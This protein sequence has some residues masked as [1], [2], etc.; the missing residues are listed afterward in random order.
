MFTIG[1]LGGVASGKSTVARMLAD[2]GALLIDADQL[3]HQALADPKIRQTLVERWGDQV[4]SA[5]DQVDRAAVGRRVFG[6][7]AQATADRRFLEG[8]I[9]P[10]VKRRSEEAIRRHADGG[11]RVAVLDIPLLLDVGWHEQCDLLLMVD[12]AQSARL[13]RASERGWDADELASREAS[14]RPIAE[15][16]RSA[17]VVLPNNGDLAA[18]EQEVAR[19]WS[20]YVVSHTGR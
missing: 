8:V 11:G 10:E 5:D 16:R 3:A 2:R 20:R 19:F 17:D 9:H 4:L 18:L 15:K 12:S 7:T 1:L 14:Q 6:D 13:A